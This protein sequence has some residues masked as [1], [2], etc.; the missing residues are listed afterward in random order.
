MSK[1]EK[2][3][4]KVARKSKNKNIIEVFPVASQYKGRKVEVGY[5]TEAG[6]EVPKEFVGK[7]II[8]S[9]LIDA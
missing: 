5:Y 8:N 7:T 9:L 2:K 4:K 3:I 1:Y 6:Q